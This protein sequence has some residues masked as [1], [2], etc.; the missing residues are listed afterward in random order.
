MKQIFFL[1]ITSVLLSA[2][3]K[4][5]AQAAQMNNRDAVAGHFE[6]NARN[7]GRANPVNISYVIV[8]A[9]ATGEIK[10]EL[11]AP[12]AVLLNVDISMHRGAF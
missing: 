11:N 9:P 4:A 1:A 2:N 7:A 10:L 3:N 5:F 12:Y 8:P 6:M